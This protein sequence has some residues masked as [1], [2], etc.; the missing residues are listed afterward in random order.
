MAEANREFG[1]PLPDN[2]PVRY[3]LG[4]A[5][6]YTGEA[7]GGFLLYPNKPNNNGAAGVYA[8]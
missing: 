3:R 4:D 5:S 1:G 2:S 6:G 7:M 8:K